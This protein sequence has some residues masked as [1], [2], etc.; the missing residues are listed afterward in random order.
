[1]ATLPPQYLYR[2]VQFHPPEADRLADKIA[3]K[4]RELT[5]Q[6]D[7][8]HT[9]A[10]NLDF[11]WEGQRKSKFMAEVDPH[12]RKLIEQIENL[13][14]QEKFFRAI[15]VTRREQYVTPA[16]EAAQRGR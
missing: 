5:A 12:K 1:M 16:W 11:S 8:V 14:R 3:Q 4:I 2:D 9:S 15:K 7:T 13:T 10:N 6:K